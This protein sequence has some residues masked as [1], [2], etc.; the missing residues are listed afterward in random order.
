MSVATI[1]QEKEQRPARQELCKKIY[2]LVANINDLENRTSA[3]VAIENIKMLQHIEKQ[4]PWSESA[5][6]LYRPSDRRLSAK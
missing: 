5:S 2:T 1:L 6:E 3:A 4:T